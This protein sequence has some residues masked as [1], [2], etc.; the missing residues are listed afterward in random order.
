[1][2]DQSPAGLVAANVRRHTKGA[3][4]MSQT[5]SSDLLD[6]L[7]LI[8]D[9]KDFAAKLAELEAAT[10]KLDVAK[11][12]ADKMSRELD[13]KAEAHAAEMARAAAAHA[14]VVK[15]QTAE[16]DAR[17]KRVAERERDADARHAEATR[18]RTEWTEKTRKMA[19]VLGA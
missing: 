18:L 10:K 15:R 1:M 6:A 12:V 4:A 17:E 19:E 11:A 9:P 14:E 16:L 8:A 3:T 7:K 2:S 13:T 5:S